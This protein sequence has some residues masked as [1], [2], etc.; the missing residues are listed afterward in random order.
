MECRCYELKLL[1]NVFRWTRLTLS[2]RLNV[3]RSNFEI[4]CE[5]ENIVI[6]RSIKQAF[7]EGDSSLRFKVVLWF[8]RH[9]TM[10]ITV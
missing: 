9:N 10:E 7:R 8:A 2:I 5:S 4:F 3:D 1:E 6:S